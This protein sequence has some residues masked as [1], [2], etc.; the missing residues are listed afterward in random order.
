MESGEDVLEGAL[1]GLLFLLEVIVP[2][3]LQSGDI[4]LLLC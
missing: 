2:V 3:A 1:T 4:S